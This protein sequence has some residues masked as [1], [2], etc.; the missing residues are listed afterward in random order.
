MMPIGVVENNQSAG[1]EMRKRDFRTI[2]AIT[3]TVDHDHV[4]RMLVAFDAIRETV[5]LLQVQRYMPP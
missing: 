3:G 4:E 5:P 2:V 1:G